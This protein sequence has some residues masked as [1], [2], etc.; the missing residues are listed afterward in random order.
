M[1]HAGDSILIQG[2]RQITVAEIGSDSREHRE[3]SE[4]TF[5]AELEEQAAIKAEKLQAEDAAEPRLRYNTRCSTPA[6]VD[7]GNRRSKLLF[8]PEFSFGITGASVGA[9][10]ADC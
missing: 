8:C 9:V 2:R 6:G 5:E 3:L 4:L 10:R 7:E 1:P